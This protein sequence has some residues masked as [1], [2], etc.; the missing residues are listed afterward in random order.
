MT[1]LG[2]DFGRFTSCVAMHKEGRGEVVAD[3]QGHREI[4]SMIGFFPDMAPAV[5]EQALRRYDRNFRNTAYDLKKMLGNS[6]TSVQSSKS[7][8][9]FSVVAGEQDSVLVK[10]GSEGKDLE[11][12]PSFCIAEIWKQ[13]KETAEDYAHTTISHAVV[14][15]PPSF[16]A[17]AEKELLEAGNLAGFTQVTFVHEPVAAV[18]AYK[19][20]DDFRGQMKNTVVIDFG[21]VLRVSHVTMHNSIP[22]LKEYKEFPE[23]NGADLDKILINWLTEEFKRKTR[24]DLS[25]SRRAKIKLQIEADRI[26]TV[27]SQTQQTNIHIEGLYEGADFISN[28][29]RARFEG[30]NSSVFNKF[31]AA[32]KQLAEA[33]GVT[34]EHDIILAGGH[35]KIPRVQSLIQS[36]FPNSKAYSTINTSEVTAQGVG[37]VG[38]LLSNRHSSVSPKVVIPTVP[39]P[40][41]IQAANGKFVPIFAKGSVMPAKVTQ[42]FATAPGQKQILINIFEGTEE[43]ASKNRQLGHFAVEVE[44]S[45]S[46]TISFLLSAESKLSVQASSGNKSKIFELTGV[47]EQAVVDK[48]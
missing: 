21:T 3:S 27:L 40:I 13:L 25:D 42:V 15:L 4:P 23:I 43:V 26:K 39:L 48:N 28:L 16:S 29:S 20:D 46:V 11:L 35:C 18:V 47:T 31:S 7:G 1:T 34:E 32:L 22:V 24:M 41:G 37:I 2:I 6:F 8:W 12:T 45:S 5:G 30:M 44:P 38:E 36:A 19:F 17:Q 33:W 10:V 14:S 9:T